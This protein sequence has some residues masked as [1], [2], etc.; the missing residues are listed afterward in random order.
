MHLTYCKTMAAVQ[1]A[2]L[3]VTRNG[4]PLAPAGLSP[5]NVH[6]HDHVQ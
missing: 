2:R 5:G 3:T 1:R 4:T 6:R